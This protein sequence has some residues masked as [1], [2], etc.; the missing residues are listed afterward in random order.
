M[1]ALAINSRPVTL[2]NVFTVE[3]TNE[4][5]LVQ[6]LTRAT[7]ESARNATGFMSERLH[8]S[9]DGTKVAMYA[10]G[11]PRARGVNR[12]RAH[13]DSMSS[14]VFAERPVRGSTLNFR[15]PSS[16]VVHHRPDSAWDKA[17]TGHYRADGHRLTVV[18][19]E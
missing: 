19:S 3:S 13:V 11:M 16:Q 5:S 10:M 15:E 8:R 2:I 17:P 4:L 1:Y 18:L 7:E 9:L 6:L 12:R 14:S